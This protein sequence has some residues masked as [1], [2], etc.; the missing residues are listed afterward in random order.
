MLSYAHILT[1]DTPSL[2]H[3]L[4]HTHSQTYSNVYTHIHSLIHTL[5]NTLSYT[6]THSLIYTHTLCLTHTYYPLR[7]T[8]TY[9]E[10][11]YVH[12]YLSSC[13]CLKYCRFSTCL[14]MISAFLEKPIPGLMVPA[15][16]LT[17]QVVL[18]LYWAAFSTGH[19]TLSYRVPLASSSSS[20]LLP[21]VS[22]PPDSDG[23]CQPV[24]CETLPWSRQ[25]AAQFLVIPFTCPSCHQHS[26]GVCLVLFPLPSASRHSASII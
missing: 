15:S 19:M 10:H 9:T 22:L 14:R 23:K 7:Q 16:S 5:T 24:G 26:V 21:E 25:Q 12:A 1:Q 2:I 11:T 4:T 13:D 6:D 18:W 3:S 8:D 20:G 17:L